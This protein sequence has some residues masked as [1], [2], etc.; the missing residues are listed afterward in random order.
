MVLD[1]KELKMQALP[2][3]GLCSRVEAHYRQI[4][5]GSLIVIRK[6][7]WRKHSIEENRAGN[8]GTPVILESNSA[9]A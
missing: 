3:S 5:H 7:K 2:S 4:R 9:K 8:D 6:R 1:T